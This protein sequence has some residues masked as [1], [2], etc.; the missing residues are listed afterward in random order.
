MDYRRIAILALDAATSHSAEAFY[1]HACRWFSKTLNTPLKEVQGYDEEYVI[2]T[3][4]ED[5]YYTLAHLEDEKSKEGLAEIRAN[6][7]KN[8]K[9][10][11]KDAE[12]EEKWAEKF[13]EA[14]VK[15]MEAA[16][17][18]GGKKKPN[19]NSD[20]EHVDVHLAGESGNFEE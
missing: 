7:I 16:V 14:W 9:E 11:A 3:F 2:R 20:I 5:Y 1:Q 10:T 19:L 8:E 6:L 13:E 18:N 12:E 17:E 4:L 15:G